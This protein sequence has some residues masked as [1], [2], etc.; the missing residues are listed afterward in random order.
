MVIYI[1][2]RFGKILDTCSNDLPQNKTLLDDKLTDDLQSGVRV[3]ECSLV[4]TKSIKEHAKPGNYIMAY[5]APYTIITSDY[6]T[7]DG[8]I[9]LYCE[10]AGLDFINKIVGPVA[11]TQKT[12]KKWIED[13]VGDTDWTFNYEIPRD[14]LKT[15][16][17]TAETTITE[18]ILDILKDYDAEMYFSYEING[19]EW[20]SRTINIVRKRGDQ[21]RAHYLRINREV[22]GI[23]ENSDISDLATVFKIYGAEEKALSSLTGYSSAPKD[24]PAE[25]GKRNHN[26]KVVG[27]EVQCVDGIDNWRSLLDKDGKITQVRTTEYKTAQDAID[28]AIRELEKVVEP[29]IT[30]E[31]E[32]SRLPDD[33][34]VG[35]FVYIKDD[36][37]EI[38]LSARVLSWEKSQTRGID[39]AILGDFTEL[40]NT[41]AKLESGSAFN[42]YSLSISSSNGLIGKDSLSTVLS[43]VVNKNGQIIDNAG[44]LTDG[45]LVWY[46][47]GTLIPSDDPR[48]L[49][50]GFKFVVDDLQTTMNYKCRLEG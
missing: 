17:Y 34:E 3:F 1:S 12:L 48:I 7:F 47:G 37:D 21:E 45:H 10:G 11:K 29:I 40:E 36:I 30:C 39:S 44:D 15:L 18:R 38:L 4:A 27:D 33:L 25:E 26:Y 43:V 13:T 16:E 35:D 46:E 41:K 31:V 19:F 2:D 49:D 8:R 23:T 28:Y 32:F 6:N 5:G 9:D 14:Q 24:Y 42:V 22:L 20:V 50:E